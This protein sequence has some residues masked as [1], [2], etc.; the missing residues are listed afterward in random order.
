VDEELSPT[1]LDN[2]YHDDSS[3]RDDP[4][5]K[6]PSRPQT[7]TLQ[8][9]LQPVPTLDED[10]SPIRG[11]DSISFH[12][13]ECLG[14]GATHFAGQVNPFNHFEGSDEDIKGTQLKDIK[15]MTGGLRKFKTQSE[16]TT[17]KSNNH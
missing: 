15:N 13:S 9:K 2:Y 1:R 7:G 8:L 6:P 17:N 5:Q 16:A 3:I 12:G 10:I 4:F 11:D 14:A